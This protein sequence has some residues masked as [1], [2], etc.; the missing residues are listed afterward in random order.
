MELK[1]ESIPNPF[2]WT[3][4]ACSGLCTTETF[5]SVQNTAQFSEKVDSLFQ[6]E[7]S[8]PDDIRSFNEMVIATFTNLASH[9]TT[10]KSGKP[11][12]NKNK[13]FDWSYRQAKRLI[14]RD[15]NNT[16]IDPMLVQPKRPRFFL[17][18]KE[19]RAQIRYRKGLGSLLIQT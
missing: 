13:W 1:F 7:I 10:Q 17:R 18:K 8:S 2:K 12:T 15:E 9:V 16:H 4:D 14:F 19:Y 6:T 5:K 11:S 3:K